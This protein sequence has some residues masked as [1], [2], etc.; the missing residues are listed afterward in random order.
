MK[1]L[2]L[3]L[4]LLSLAGC[5]SAEPFQLSGLSRGGG[6]SPFLAGAAS[7]AFTP[8]PGY[9]LGGY[10]GGGRRDEWPL[11]FGIGWPG[12]LAL[13]AHQSWHEDDPEGRADMLHGAEGVH[14]DLMARA[15]VLRPQAP[16][17]PPVA[18]VKFD[19]IG[20]TLE[21]H[22]LVCALVADL[23]YEKQTV[24]LA[25]THTHSGVGA[26]MRE[27]MACLA[28]MDNFRPEVEAALAQACADAIRSAHESA[29]P[30]L[31]G[32]GRARDRSAE[33]APLIAKNRRARRFKDEIEY[34]A[35]DDE[36]G[37][38][39]VRDAGSRAPIGLLV[40]YAVHPTL[41]GSDNLKFSGDV[42]GAIERAVADRIGAPA[43]FFNGAEGD[44]GPQ[45]GGL[46]DKLAR[47]G[48][49][50]EL[51]ADLV[52]PVVSEIPMHAAIAVTAAIG[53]KE[54]GSP[55]TLVALG[56]ER[57]I[58]GEAGVTGWLTEPLTLP[59]NLVLWTLGFTNIRVVVTWNLGLGVIAQLNTLIGRTTTRVGG[60]RI[61][62][63]DE[64]VALLGLPGEA[65]HDVGLA[66]RAEAASRGATR[67]F[68]LGLT[69]DHIGYI[70]SRSEYRRGGY[71]AQSTLFGEGTAD[72]ILEADRAVLEALG[73]AAPEAPSSQ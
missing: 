29:R 52:A 26:Y 69:H 33:G 62:A 22:D 67:S 36:I 17:A 6:R 38:L 57:F 53:D 41:L 3:L 58:D 10:G 37:L 72:A 4:A 11:Y 39:L 40:N 47:C 27:P 49:L 31:L 18:L 25:A 9:P 19:G 21:L 32:F 42:G 68:V 51:M 15:L 55:R 46:P 13:A 71:E 63:G 50:G 35:I 61:Q 43:L 16:H 1:R 7:V 28:A 64:D 34:D 20:T 44:I 30:A 59:L 65:T 54:L 14:D 8:E 45:S 60:L 73:F 56:R 23:G 5:A 2:L 12:Q 24:V 66:L 48:E 70:A